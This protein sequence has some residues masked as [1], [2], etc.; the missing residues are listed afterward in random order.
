MSLKIKDMNGKEIDLMFLSDHSIEFETN[1]ESTNFY[2][3]ADQIK[4]LHK[5]LGDYI[6]NNPLVFINL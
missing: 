1:N 2:L 5:I 3:E 6:I 4:N